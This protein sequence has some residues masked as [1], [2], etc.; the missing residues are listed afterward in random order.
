ME[1]KRSMD[2]ARVIGLIRSGN[3]E[4]FEELMVRY[5]RQACFLAFRYL[6]NWEE[7]DDITQT[8]FIRL[9]EFIAK[10]SET[11]AVLPWIRKVVVNLCLD[12]QKSK[13]WRLFFR[14][15]VRSGESNPGEE[16]ALDPLECIEERGASP[17]DAY[18]N[19]ELRDR[20]ESL[21]EALPGQQRQIFTM[22]QFEGLKITEIA[23]ELTISE[24][25]VK[26]QLFRAVRTLRKGLGEF[27]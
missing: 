10:R 2:D 11:I 5:Q 25:Q 17:E 16:K 6:K 24:G 4:A 13:K 19:N 8:A 1:P 3:S 7:A 21:V 15:V 20:I 18:L 12:K 9:Y 22:K 23:S 26:S 14:N 27:L